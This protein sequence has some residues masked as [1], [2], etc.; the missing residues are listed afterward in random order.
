MKNSLRQILRRRLRLSTQSAGETSDCQSELR[1]PKLTVARQ[2]STQTT[3]PEFRGLLSA[4]HAAYPCGFFLL[5]HRDRQNNQRRRSAWGRYSIETRRFQLG[6]PYRQRHLPHKQ[7]PRRPRR[8]PQCHSGLRATAYQRRFR[9]RGSPCGFRRKMSSTLFA[10]REN[11]SG[12]STAEI[13]VV[14]RRRH[15]RR[16]KR[17][18]ETIGRHPGVLSAVYCNQCRCYEI[19]PREKDCYRR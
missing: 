4:R 2:N 15:Q 18:R 11:K 19:A 10:P 8:V 7:S 1:S 17:K 6:T 13:P 9:R 5:S 12:A 14:A 16:C 3:V